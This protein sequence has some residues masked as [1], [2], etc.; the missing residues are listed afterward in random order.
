VR[1]DPGFGAAQTKSAEAAALAAGATVTAAT[2]EASLKGTTE[3]AIVAAAQQGNPTLGN[4][5][6]GLGSTVKNTAGDLNP[7]A[8]GIATSAGGV[9]GGSTQPASKDPVSSGLGSDNPAS[10][11]TVTIVITRPKTP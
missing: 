4:E 2:V 8:T 1:L 3:G 7:S 10:T 6:V 9:G 11:A 5:A